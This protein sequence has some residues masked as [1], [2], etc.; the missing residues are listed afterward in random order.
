MISKSLEILKGPSAAAIYG[1]RAN[2]GV[3]IITTKRGKEGRTNV[4]I[5]QDFGVNR[6]I[7]LLGMRDWTEERVRASFNEAEAQSFVTARNAGQIYDYEK[8]IY[9]ETGPISQTNLSISGGGER[10]RFFMGAS[11]RNEDGIIK[12][13][14]FE[15]NS[16]RLNIDHDI[17]RPL[18]DF[19]RQ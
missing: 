18:Y 2:A 13:T 16:I 17:F 19:Y 5:S 8:E 1:T 15:R 9:G 14:G 7:R 12:N 10:T 4:S 11:V 6:A 3:V